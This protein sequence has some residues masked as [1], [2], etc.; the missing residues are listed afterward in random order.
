LA[1][2]PSNDLLVSLSHFSAD[3]SLI[4][5]LLGEEGMH[6]LSKLSNILLV[7]LVI[8]LFLFTSSICVLFTT[9]EGSDGVCIGM[10]LKGPSVV[11]DGG[12][13]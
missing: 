7:G 11:G 12:N 2:K 8:F 4:S 3:N 10:K 6:S 13:F 1:E 5:G 9:S